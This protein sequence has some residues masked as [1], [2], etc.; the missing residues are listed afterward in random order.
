MIIVTLAQLAMFAYSLAENANRTGSAIQLEPLNPMIG[1][2]MEILVNLGAKFQACMFP[3]D[4]VNPPVR[5]H[6]Y[7]SLCILTL[8]FILG[9]S[10]CI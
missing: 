8:M 5:M 3:A 2:N 9:M 10:A 4:F 1:P 6:A 7:C